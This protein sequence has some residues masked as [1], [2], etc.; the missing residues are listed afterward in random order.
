[1]S[2]FNV[3]NEEKQ[4]ILEMH[5]GATKNQYLTESGSQTDAQKTKYSQDIA[6]IQ[7]EFPYSTSGLQELAMKVYNLQ[8]DELL[9]AVQPILT[10]QPMLNVIQKYNPTGWQMYIEHIQDTNA[11]TEKYAMSP[12][13]STIHGTGQMLTPTSAYQ[14]MILDLKYLKNGLITYAQKMAGMAINEKTANFY[15]GTDNVNSRQMDVLANMA[16]TIG[17]A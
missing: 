16:R 1:M 14:G 7:N 13:G 6:K 4:R 2:I 8:G 15:L 9:T 17:I 12:Y 10:N 3:S 5:Q 11:S